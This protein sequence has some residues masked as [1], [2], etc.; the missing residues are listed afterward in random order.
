MEYA[1]H[2]KH[3]QPYVFLVHF[4]KTLFTQLAL[5]SQY[6]LNC[7][8]IFIAF[9]QNAFN[10]TFSNIMNSF[11]TQ[12]RPPPKHTVFRTDKFTFKT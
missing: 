8:S 12:T 2:G 11:L 4:F 1:T 3:V 10:E 9:T 5:Q 7:K 6:G